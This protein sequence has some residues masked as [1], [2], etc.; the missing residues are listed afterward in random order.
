ML[1]SSLLR[2]EE[3]PPRVRRPVAFDL[4]KLDID[5]FVVFDKLLLR[6]ADAITDLFQRLLGRIDRI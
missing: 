3:T 2:L 1:A 5:V 4:R 6:D